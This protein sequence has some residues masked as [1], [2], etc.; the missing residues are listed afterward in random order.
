VA[1]GRFL[2][3]KTEYFRAIINRGPAAKTSSGGIMRQLCS[4]LAFAVFAFVSVTPARA[5]SEKVLYAFTGGVDGG[6]PIGSLVR[7]SSGNLY[8]TTY[9]GG[10]S[11]KNGSTCYPNYGKRP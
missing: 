1:R 5:A 2:L 7:D 10:A 9:H 8:G 4:L 6:N 3:D 11:G